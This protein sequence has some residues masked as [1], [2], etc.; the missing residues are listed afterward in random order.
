VQLPD[1]GRLG[2]A[3]FDAASRLQASLTLSAPTAMA[4][5]LQMW[6]ADD[7]RWL[8]SAQRTLDLPSGRQELDLPLAGF[9]AKQ[10]AA[11]AEMRGMPIRRL[12][13]IA[14]SGSV[15][16]VVHRLGMRR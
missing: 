15:T 3:S 10:G 6:S 14:W 1:P 12:S 8:G 4:V 7:S 9:E 13:L 2:I 5:H 16:V 11:L